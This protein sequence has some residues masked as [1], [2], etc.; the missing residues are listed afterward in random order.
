MPNTRAARPA[1]RRFGARGGAS[2]PAPAAGG[3]GLVEFA[4]VLT[5]LML[6]LVGIIQMG[7]VFNAYVT[8]SNATRE[9]ARAASVFVY[10]RSDTK[11]E[12]DA[13]RT[14]AARAALT[15]SMGLL[16]TTSP[17]LV[18][19]DQVVTYSVPDSVA[20]SDARAGHHVTVHAHYHLDMMIPFIAVLLP[21]ENGRLPI[22]AEVTMVI[23]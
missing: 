5:P 16:P 9:A 6:L 22:D 8:V 4:L 23:N 15:A 1:R 3:Q 21:L 2:S 17:Q 14:A 10:D 13:A 20:E 7:L 18:P 11:A 19:S 12:N